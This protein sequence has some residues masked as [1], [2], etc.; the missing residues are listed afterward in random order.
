MELSSRDARGTDE[1]H[2]GLLRPLTPMRLEAIGVY[3]A[4]RMTEPRPA[5]LQTLGRGD[6]GALIGTD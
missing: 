6:D 1:H 4:R 2:P 5:R 3:A